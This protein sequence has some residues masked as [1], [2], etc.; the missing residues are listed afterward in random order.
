MTKNTVKS[1]AKEIASEILKKNEE[2]LQEHTVRKAFEYYA[3]TKDVKES[4]RKDKVQLLKQLETKGYAD[5]PIQDMNGATIRDFLTKLNLSESSTK[6]AYI[7]LTG[8][9]RHYCTE[10]HL[11]I[12][13]PKG[14][15]K[16][17]KLKAIESDEYLNWTELQGL[18]ALQMED[19]DDQL[20]VD[21][22]CLMA[23]SGMAVG[24][25]LKF[26]PELHVS[27]DWRWI[28]YRRH[29]TNSECCIPLLPATK[30]I[31]EAHK[32]PV[33]I[34]K[35]W[36]QK[37]CETLISGLVGKTMKS[38]SARKTAGCVFLELGFTMEATSKMLGHSSV[39]IT[40]AH[41]AKITEAKIN[42]EMNN[43]PPA[44]KAMMG[45]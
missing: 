15:I 27:P 1:L 25:M 35:R 44:I 30:R 24:D 45:V 16:S 40:Q 33:K 39:L 34:S 37:K 43:L 4:T 17:V 13:I 31:I 41:Y 5:K 29:K 32:W 23:L 8:V 36:I 14:L 38:H 19:E 18:L 7:R 28:K 3:K 26:N 21:I 11:K 6:A 12:E 10:N 22:F 20:Y 42:R 2:G 9:L